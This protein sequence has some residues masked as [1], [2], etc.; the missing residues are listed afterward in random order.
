[1]SETGTVRRFTPPNTFRAK[2][3]SSGGVALEQMQAAADEALAKLQDQSHS[4]LQSDVEKLVGHLSGAAAAADGAAVAGHVK[5]IS[6]ITHDLKALAMQFEFPLI[7]RVGHSLCDFIVDTP[8]LAARRLDVI[9][10]HVD[11]V[12]VI[13]ANGL[14]GEGGIAGTQL[15][16]ALERAVAKAR[17]QDGAAAV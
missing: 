12:V 6:K 16:D 7:S 11:A 9:R 8:E 14:S 15:I 10:V 17:A 13:L 3:P 2:V 1:M 4:W 5:E